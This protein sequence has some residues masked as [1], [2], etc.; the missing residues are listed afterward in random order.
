MALPAVVYLFLFSYLP[1]AGL[2]IAFQKYSNRG[3]IFGSPFVG[4]NNFRFLF[5][6]T[7]AWRITRNTVLYNLTFIAVNMVL[8]LALAM[9]LS[10]LR[11]RW[12]A[13]FIQTI[14]MMPYFL[15]WTVINIVVYA[16]L[17][18]SDGLVNALLMEATGEAIKID[19]YQQI[20]IWP[21][22][23]VF[24]NAW[25]SGG[26]QTVLFLAVISSISS[27]YYEAAMLDGATKVQQAWYITLPHLRF[28]IGISIILAM[29]NIFRGD[30]GLF[31]TVTRNSGMLY[32]VTDVIDTY[33]YR[34]LMSLSNVSMSA[35]AGFY[36]SVV[37]FILIII[38]NNIV[39]KIDPD[40]AMF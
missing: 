13:K 26:Y 7:D 38:V 5:S 22:L 9:M 40:S 20:R 33:I 8:A 12:K 17:D 24:L 10:E 4:L 23:L 34:G 18:R 3:G 39:G 27:D 6:S 29:G 2:V 15:S 30:F 28:V 36:Q 31:Y 32:P 21:P 16:F 25:K 19:W 35:A 11:S 37:G 1:M 14:Y